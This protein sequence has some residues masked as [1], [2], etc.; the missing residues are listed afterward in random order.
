MVPGNF[1][2]GSA[3]LAAI[4]ML[5]PSFAALSAMAFPIPLL[6]PVIN[7][8]LPA[9]LLGKEEDVCQRLLQINQGICHAYPVFIMLNTFKCTTFDIAEY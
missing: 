5:A 7:K 1:G 2:C 8:V 6:A 9:S 3:V 4:T